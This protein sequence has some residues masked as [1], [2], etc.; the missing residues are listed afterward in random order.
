MEKKHLAFI[1]KTISHALFGI[2]QVKNILSTDCLRTFTSYL[3]N[4]SMRKCKR[5]LISPKTIVLQ[6]R[7]MRI[8]EA[9][10]NSHTEPLLKKSQILRVSDMFE[11]HVVL[12]MH[13]FLMRKLPS[14]FNKTYKLNYEIQAAHHTRQ[15]DLIYIERCNSTVASKLP[16][17]TFSMI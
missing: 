8:N 16:Y 11:Y 9:Q 3:W 2:K 1:N 14:S 12:F 7:T 13:D 17:Y 4:P 6:K 10:Y 15:E 5:H